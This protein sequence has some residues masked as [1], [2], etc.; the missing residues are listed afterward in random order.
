VNAGRGRRALRSAC[1]V[2]AVG[3]VIAGCTDAQAPSP[4]STR[5]ASSAPASFDPLGGA[6]PT[7]V[8]T[9]LETPWSIAFVGDTALVSERDSG[10]VLEVAPDGTTRTV[11]TIAGISHGGEGGL[12]GLA[13]ADERLYAYS[14]G[15]QGN[16]IQRFALSGAP[17]A[18][19]GLELG[20]PETILDGLASAGFHNGGRIAFGPDGMLYAGVGDAGSADRAQDL[21]SLSGKILRMTPEGDA[22]DDNPFPDSLVYSSGHRNVQGLAWAEDGTMFASEFGQD[23]WD[24]LN[25]IEAGGDYGWP[26]VEG[27]GEDVRFIDPV[28]QWSPADASPSGITVID[29]V[30]YI[31]NL[32]GSVL[33][34]VPVAEPGS[35]TEYFSGAYGRFRA[36]TPAPDGSLWVLTGNTNS[37]GTPRDGDD[38]IVR[39][40]VGD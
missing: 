1:V 7:E 17:G 18:P 31:A 9:G 35:S 26:T 29:D 5:T 32:R 13:V 22:P 37:Q 23:T 6:R 36:V 10:R 14:T 40:D 38:R 8:T 30:V 24:E 11:A 33:R 15:E 28:Q 12:L 21:D 27:A 2:T 34:A 39:V 3:I 20:E 16:R 19:G 4:T 25:I